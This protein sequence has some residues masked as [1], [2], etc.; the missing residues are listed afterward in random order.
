L[1]VNVVDIDNQHQQLF[2]LFDSIKQD[3][4]TSEGQNNIGEK[5]DLLFK[6]VHVAFETE[7][8]YFEKF[9]YKDVLRHKEEH[10]DFLKKLK[11]FKEL[12]VSSKPGTALFELNSLNEW[13]L[14]HVSVSDDRFG[15]FIRKNSLNQ[16]LKASG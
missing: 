16:F 11:N 7:E 3:F 4:K 5:L 13:F 8:F 14:N 2:S 9:E 6:A 1:S 12:S 15:D 10:H